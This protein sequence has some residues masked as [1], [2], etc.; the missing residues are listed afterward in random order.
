MNFIKVHMRMC[1]V[2]WRK[3]GQISFGNCDPVALQFCAVTCI[4]RKPLQLT[5]VAGAKMV[6]ERAQVFPEQ[7]AK[8]L[9]KGFIESSYIG[10]TLCGLIFLKAPTLFHR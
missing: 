2:Q 4:G 5:G 7:F 9:P 10:S 6:T 1:A 8:A 3:V